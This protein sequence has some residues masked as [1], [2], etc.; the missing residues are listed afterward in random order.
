MDAAQEVVE[1]CTR[2]HEGVCQRLEET[3]NSLKQLRSEHDGALAVIAALTRELKVHQE[4]ADCS[5]RAA[6]VDPKSAHG[7]NFTALPVAETSLRGSEDGLS[8]SEAVPSE[9]APSEAAAE[10]DVEVG[11]RK[12]VARV[13]RYTGVKEVTEPP[14]AAPGDAETSPAPPQTARAGRCRITS[15]A[16]AASWRSPLGSKSQN[17]QFALIQ[18]E[19]LRAATRSV[20]TTTT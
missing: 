9:T 6:M 12:G 19:K 8:P 14:A 2:D 18:A 5:P 20:A 4:A 17:S 10:G 7:R 11:S 3:E 1:R 13:L 16:A 15:G